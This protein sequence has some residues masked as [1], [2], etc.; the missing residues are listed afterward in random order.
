MQVRFVLYQWSLLPQFGIGQR[1]ES[2][3]DSNDIGDPIPSTLLPSSFEYLNGTLVDDM[4]MQTQ[5]FTINNNNAKR[6]PLAKWDLHGIMVPVLVPGMISQFP[7]QK[8][9]M[10]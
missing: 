5:T 3:A 2:D 9:E 7:Q 8:E 1:K 4:V 6:I 10:F